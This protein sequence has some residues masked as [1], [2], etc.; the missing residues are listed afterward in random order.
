MQIS[1][2]AS[3]DVTRSDAECALNVRNGVR[4]SQLWSGLL[5][6]LH[7]SR[8]KAAA[9]E[10]SRYRHLNQ[11]HDTSALRNGVELTPEASTSKLSSRLVRLLAPILLVGF[12]AAHVMAAHQ[13]DA[14][15]RLVQP[16]PSNELIIPA[17]D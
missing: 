15:H 14:A 11:D 9:R 10:L 16:A 4:R 6:A 2:A 5:Q 13:I 7:E 3:E 17:G 12:A 1:A 8:L